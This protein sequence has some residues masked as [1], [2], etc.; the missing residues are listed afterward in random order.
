MAVICLIL[1]KFVEGL[2]LDYS[3]QRQD[4]LLVLYLPALFGAVLSCGI[5]FKS[6]KLWISHKAPGI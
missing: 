4:A 3:R 2:C 1:V 5:I 6:D